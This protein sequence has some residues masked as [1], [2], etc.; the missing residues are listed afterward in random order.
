MELEIF[1]ER[2]DL[3]SHLADYIA[4][5]AGESIDDHG[6]FNFVLAGGNSP[7]VLYEKL[8][9]GKY[10]DKIEWDK[11]WFF[12]GDERYVPIDDPD[13]NARMARET[14]L[15]P[16]QIS[17]EQI[18]DFDTTISAEEAARKYD[19]L[20]QRHFDGAT[21]RFDFILLGLG[22][23]AHTASLFPHTG[24]LSEQ[25]ARVAAV[26]VKQL[27]LY[28]LTMTA[29]MINNARHIAFL[30]FGRDKAAAVYHVL[31]DKSARPEKY[32][33]KLIQNVSD[34]RITWFLDT[35]AAEKL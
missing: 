29:P 34:N 4:K 9:S 22:S 13:R 32:P 27:D 24:V 19:A 3:T 21:P 8:A 7:R 6:K 11:T 33:A 14:L 17:K 31:E 26:F 15:E 20:I 35:A 18:M 1:T 10:R 5:V 25:R 16:L 12:F 28:R 2:A 23:D 30:V